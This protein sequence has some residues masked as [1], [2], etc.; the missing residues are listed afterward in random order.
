MLDDATARCSACTP[1]GDKVRRD[2]IAGALA[3]LAG[4]Q[5]ASGHFSL[6]GGEDMV[7]PSL[8][9]YVAEF[10]LDARDAGFAVPEAMLQKALKALNEDLLVR[11]HAVLRLRPPRAPDVRVPRARRLRA[12]P[13]QPRAARHAARAVRRRTR[14]KP[15]PGLPL[16]RLGI[17]LS[18]QGDRRR[19][20]KAIAEGFAFDDSDRPDTSATTA[21]AC[22]TT[23]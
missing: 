10:L 13:R 6:W 15:E 19:G 1:L 4:M 14:A 21:R 18:L 16:V 23:R 22:A 20:A 3:R 5:V 11:R 2:R 9:P 8:T 12:R 17:A 7:D